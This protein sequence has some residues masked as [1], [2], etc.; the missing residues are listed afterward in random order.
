MAVSFAKTI[1]N[2]CKKITSDINKINVYVHDTAMLIV[3][4]AA[5]EALNG[6]HDCSFAKNLVEAMPKSYRLEMLKTWFST[7]TPILVKIDSKTNAISVGFD[8]EYKKIAPAD[9]ATATRKDGS[10]WWNLE[11]AQNDP[12]YAIAERTP[13]KPAF[14]LAAMLKLLENT[15]KRIE[16]EALSENSVLSDIEKAAAIEVSHKVANI[17]T[18]LAE[19]KLEQN[20]NAV[21]EAMANAG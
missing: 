9:K 13:E 7:Y 8:T 15:A 17:K 14:D 12:F 19:R 21:E 16:K 1:N 11:A 18:N 3:N 20:D 10:L 6:H 5:P 2:R 4:H